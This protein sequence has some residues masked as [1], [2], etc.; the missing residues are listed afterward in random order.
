MS[1]L[2]VSNS[3]W[4]RVDRCFSKQEAWGDPLKISGLLLMSLYQIRF[5]SSWPILI[6]CGTQGVHCKGSFHYKGLAADF[7]FKTPGDSINFLEQINYLLQFL[8][9]M[10][11]SNSCGLGLYPAWYHPGFHFDVRGYRARWGKINDEYCS[12]STALKFVEEDR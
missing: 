3:I 6:H 9:E 2:L 12:F 10:Q 4:D 1:K 7:H 8:D 5:A 11:L